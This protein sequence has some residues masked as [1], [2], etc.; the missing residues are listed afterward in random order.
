MRM[1]KEGVLIRLFAHNI[2]ISVIHYNF[3][4]AVSHCIQRNS[5]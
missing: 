3:D 2:L 5:W 1:K 4:L